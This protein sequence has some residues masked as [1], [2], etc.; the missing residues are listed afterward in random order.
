MATKICKE[1]GR[2]KPLT[3]Y[4]KLPPNR[5]SPDGLRAICKACAKSNARNN[6]TPKTEG[7]V[8]K[9]R[10]TRTPEERGSSVLKPGDYSHRVMVLGVRA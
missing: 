7:Y 6:Y 8:S 9:P 3:E 2:D 5:T 10:P 1:C 4:Y